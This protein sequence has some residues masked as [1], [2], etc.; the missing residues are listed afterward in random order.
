MGNIVDLDVLVPED[1]EVKFKSKDGREYTVKLFIPAAVGFT[2][3]DNL[4]ALQR[5]FPGG[6]NSRP[7]LTKE[8]IDLALRI[9]ADVIG[10]QYP[11]VDVDWVRTNIS[12]PRLAVLVLKLSLPVYQFLTSSGF[13]EAAQP[14][15]E[16]EMFTSAE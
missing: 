14:V 11:E 1:E 12:L 8:S 5:I 10:E 3:I 9:V 15:K 13:L 2:I 6:G 7:R 4:D 16:P